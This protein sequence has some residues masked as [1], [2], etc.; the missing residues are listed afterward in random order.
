MSHALTTKVLGLPLLIWKIK[1]E[2]DIISQ[3]LKANFVNIFF[4]TAFYFH[5]IKMAYNIKRIVYDL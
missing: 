1:L 3:Y 2:Y 5:V 4:L